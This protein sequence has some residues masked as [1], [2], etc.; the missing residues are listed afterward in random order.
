MRLASALLVLVGA[1]AGAQARY[2]LFS[3]QKGEAMR[4]CRGDR[5]TG[6]AECVDGTGEAV[7]TIGAQPPTWT[8]VADVAVT[9]FHFPSPFAERAED[10][11]EF[12]V[13]ASS[14][15]ARVCVGDTATGEAICA[16]GTASYATARATGKPGYLVDPRRTL[17]RYRY[18]HARSGK[19]GTWTFGSYQ[20]RSGPR[21]CVMNTTTSETV[22][23]DGTA[24]VSRGR[25]VHPP[26]WEQ[27][28]IRPKWL[29]FFAH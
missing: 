24:V 12:F 22:C 11:Y 19:I 25:A 18:F 26:Q 16:D 15:Q 14:G 21:V 1:S 13:Y 2:Q 6:V 9:W 3:Y 5:S 28:P 10:R 17:T 20:A 8:G 27:A 4:L 29:R 23:T 7:Q